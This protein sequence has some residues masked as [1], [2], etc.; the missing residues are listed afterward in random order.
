M[1]AT[2]KQQISGLMAMKAPF[3]MKMSFCHASFE[4]RF[5]LE[6]DPRNQRRSHEVCTLLSN[7][8]ISYECTSISQR[9]YQ[10]FPAGK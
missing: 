9:D 6:T 3:S 8:L 10:M 5:D 2:K 7:D 4:L 1:K